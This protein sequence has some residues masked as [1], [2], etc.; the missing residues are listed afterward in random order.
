[1]RSGSASSPRS[2][3]SAALAAAPT[4]GVVSADHKVRPMDAPATTASASLEA[5]KNEFEA[6]QIVL[7]APVGD[8]A[9]VSI[10]LSKPLAGPNGASIP[11]EDVTLYRE[12]YYDV[13]T[14]SNS[15]G[16]A[17][18]WPDPLVPDV[19]TYVGERR[20][21]FPLDVPEG[22]SRVVWVDVLV[23]EDATPGDWRSG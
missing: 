6:F 8:A 7:T 10:A 16:A 1:L 3:E 18:L 4:F 12:A 15:E 13:G 17:G 23:P 9:G 22:A 11:A 20:D 5:A 14:P 21:A 19:D 2:G